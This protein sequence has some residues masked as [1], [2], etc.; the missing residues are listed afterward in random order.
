MCSYFAFFNIVDSE[1]NLRSQHCRGGSTLPAER[2]PAFHCVLEVFPLICRMPEYPLS[3]TCTW[4]RCVVMASLY[5]ILQ[6]GIFFVSLFFLCLSFCFVV[7]VVV[8]FVCYLLCC[9][10]LFVFFSL[11]KAIA[12]VA[13][14]PTP[15]AAAPPAAA[16]L[17][18]CRTLPQVRLRAHCL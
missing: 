12:P 2:E 3:A 6:L 18:V 16:P 8:V 15:P 7:D 11:P 13:A 14:Q 9:G 10:R 17:R 5:V 4:C 1:T